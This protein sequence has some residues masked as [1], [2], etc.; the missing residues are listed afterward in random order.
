VEGREEE[1]RKRESVS[2]KMRKGRKLTYTSHGIGQQTHRQLVLLQHD[3]IRIRNL[4]IQALPEMLQRGLTDR[5]SVSKPPTVRLDST[6]GDV[7]GL[8]LGGLDDFPVGVADGFGGFAGE[9]VD[10]T[11]GFRVA[12]EVLTCEDGVLV[13]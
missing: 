2:G 8:E 11:S 1:K 6:R 10:A 9:E 3:R 4:L 5:P 13:A 7:G 12:V